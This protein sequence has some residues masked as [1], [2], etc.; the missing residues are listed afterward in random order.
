M[1]EARSFIS[2]THDTRAMAQMLKADFLGDYSFR[3]IIFTPVDDDLNLDL[4]CIRLRV[5][6]IRHKLD[7]K[8]VLSEK[9]NT[10][11]GFSKTS[12]TPW[13]KRF[14]TLRDAL[15]YISAYRSDLQRSLEYFRE[16]WKFQ[17]PKGFLYAEDMKVDDFGRM[18]EIE[19]ETP[20]DVVAYFAELQLT[21]IAHS[22]PEIMRR[23]FSSVLMGYDFPAP[24]HRVVRAILLD[25][26]QRVLV[27]KR[28]MG[29][30]AGMWNL[31]GGKQDYG[32]TVEEAIDREVREEVAVF[33]SYRLYRE[34]IGTQFDPLG[35]PW[36]TTIFVGMFD[37]IVRANVEEV[38]EVALVTPDT[39]GQFAWTLGHGNLL[40]EFFASSGITRR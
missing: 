9:R 3:D 14:D 5:T 11:S 35:I 24:E 16:G 6:T 21:P 27:G 2:R 40:R 4:R 22:L 34:F 37:G 1:Y 15:R 17:I 26:R 7:R 31:I 30:E 18:L 36:L 19:A 38:S 12:T 20:A 39:L 33:A 29:S 13:E 28:A 8:I 10:W 23:Y 25:E 32:E